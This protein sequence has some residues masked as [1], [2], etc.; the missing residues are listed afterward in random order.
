VIPRGRRRL[1]IG[2]LVA[3][4]A[5]GAAAGSGVAWW[6]WD[7]ARQPVVGDAVAVLD[8]AVAEVVVAAGPEVAVALGGVVRSASCQIDVLRTGGE[9]TASAD[10]YTDLGREDA[11]IAAIGQQLAGSYPVRRGTAV[12]GVRPLTADAPGG[13]LVS[14]RKLGDGWLAVSARTGCSL[15]SA[16]GPQAPPAG[17][18]G[19]GEITAA[20]ATLGATPAAFTQQSLPCAGTSLVTVAAVSGS[21][22]SSHLRQRLS[23]RI[24]ATAHVFVAGKSN[25]VVYRA[26]A[27]SV[28]VAASDD[29]TAVTGQYTSGCAR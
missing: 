24:P 19:A 20:F 12:S 9:F 22:D 11:T 13:V 17:S 21:A 18:A 7:T 1:L 15:G 26:G 10:L 16:P 5:L 3:V 8:K 14:V 23:T 2:G 25:R 28:V 4:V 29:G 6:R 27:V